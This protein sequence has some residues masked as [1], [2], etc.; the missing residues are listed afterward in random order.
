ML[1]LHPYDVKASV[2]AGEGGFLI[3][4]RYGEGL[5]QSKQQFFDD[6]ALAQLSEQITLFYKEAA[7]LCKKML[8]ADY[9]K[10]IKP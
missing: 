9:Y 7:E 1:H 4:L 5:A 2:I 6:E 3:V 8:I 10:L